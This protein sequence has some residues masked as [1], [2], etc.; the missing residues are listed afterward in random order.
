MPGD[1]AHFTFEREGDLF[2]NFLRRKSRYGRVDLD[3]RIGDVRHGIE[4]QKELRF[5]IDE[6]GLRREF[7]DEE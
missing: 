3:L 2:F 5:P 1:A 7:D 6:S 4:R